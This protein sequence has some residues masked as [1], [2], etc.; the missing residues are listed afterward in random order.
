MYFRI[1]QWWQEWTYYFGLATASRTTWN[2]VLALY[3]QKPDKQYW[4]ILSGAEDSIIIINYLNIIAWNTALFHPK[5]HPT[6]FKIILEK[7]A[8]NDVILDYVLDNFEIIKP[9]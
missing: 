8:R 5:D 3:E 1:P 4:K 7:H 9:T 2:K 6:I